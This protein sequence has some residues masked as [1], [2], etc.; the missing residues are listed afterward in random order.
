MAGDLDEGQGRVPA[1]DAVAVARADAHRVLLPAPG[2]A[3]GDVAVG[4][5]GDRA[6]SGLGGARGRDLSP[7]P[8]HPSPPLSSPR[9]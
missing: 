2:D 7:F 4:R 5:V 8:F 1:E 9:L 3:A 6:V